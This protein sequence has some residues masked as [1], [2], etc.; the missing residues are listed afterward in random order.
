[1][2]TEP[3]VRR[4]GLKRRPFADFILFGVTSVELAL[5]CS[6]TPTFTLIDWI[7]VSSNLLV[8]VFALT[9]SPA[10]V[11]DRSVAASAAVLVS[12]TY[13]YAQV[14]W[15]RWIPGHP[16]W[17]VGGLVLVIVGA[18]ASLTSLLNL[19]HRFGVRPALRG[20]ATH[21]LYRIVRH[22]LYLAYMIADVGYNLQEWN[23]GTVL[24]VA[25]G[26]ISMLYRI[27]AEERVLSRDANW[28]NYAA[29]VRFRLVPFVW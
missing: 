5:L 22:P 28:A 20:V 18:C 8:L 4:W 15:L 16:A 14:A 10:Q 24:L 23:S 17:P 21:G 7:Y 27:R 2:M 6:L 9:R 19:G 13:T 25:V 12:Y 1:M 3:R 26:W 11:Q 29:R